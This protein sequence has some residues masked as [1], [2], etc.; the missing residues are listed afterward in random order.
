MTGI[1]RAMQQET[2][3]MQ[4]EIRGLLEEIKNLSS[5][6]IAEEAADR[7]THE[8]HSYSVYGYI[9]QLRKVIKLLE[10]ETDPQEV[11]EIVDSCIDIDTYIQE[12]LG[13][14]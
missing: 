10:E 3:N 13:K 4:P 11:V 1:I 2:I 5:S 8:K 6:E 12:R 14:E 9:N 7:L